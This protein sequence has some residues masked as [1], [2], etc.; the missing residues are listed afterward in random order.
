MIAPPDLEPSPELLK[1]LQRL[2]QQPWLVAPP[3]ALPDLHL[4]PRLEAPSSLA[5]A[6]RDVWV[7]GLTSPSPHCGMAL[8]LTDLDLAFATPARLDT[9]F[10]E[11]AQRLALESPHPVDATTLNVALLQGAPGWRDRS[12]NVAWDPVMRTVEGAFSE[13][14]L[15]QY[16]PDILSMIPGW[17]RDMARQVFGLVGRGN[18]FLELQVVEEI[19]N[20]DIAA[21]WGV[22]EGQLTWMVHADSGPLGSILGRLFA[23]RRKMPRGKR[24]QE[25][26]VK[27]PYHLHRTSSPIRWMERAR[28]FWPGRW[29]PIPVDSE[30]GNLCRW[31]MGVAS[32]YA[33]ANREEIWRRTATAL[34]DVVG[35]AHLR[36][37]WDAPHNGI[38]PEE[39]DGHDCWIHRHNAARVLPGQPVLIPG[40]AQT[41][42]YLCIGAANAA[43]ALYSASHGAGYAIQRLSDSLDDGSSTTRVYG[44]STAEVKEL[45]HVSRDGID[46]V[47][48]ALAH[49]E[50]AQPVARLRPL[51]SLKAQ[52][53]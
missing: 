49:R 31:A 18:H 11:L 34:D 33:D 19:S 12:A 20:P 43:A 41:S 13:D 32:N 53:R 45:P 42:S 10:G 25:W 35:A 37:L 9:L 15:A 7:L 47:V 24:W 22:H 50:I 8:A 6:T 28:V 36:V 16:T 1:M 44:Y 39:I 4:K 51:A 2:A 21:R 29:V 48:T 40:S 14:E 38:W 5:T 26:R 30:T 27:F 46:A 52:P 17:L 23:H 3:V